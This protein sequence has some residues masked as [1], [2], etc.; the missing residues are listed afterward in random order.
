M[1]LSHLWDDSEKDMFMTKSLIAFTLC[2]IAVISVVA[3]EVSHYTPP[4]I[5]Y[6]TPSADENGAMILGN[7]EIGATAWI[8]GEGTLHS[9]FQ[10]LAFYAFQ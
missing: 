2:F 9:V 10:R 1:I 3:A 7:G 5:V 4:S 6:D 8:D